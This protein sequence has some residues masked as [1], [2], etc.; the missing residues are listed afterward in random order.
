MKD[1]R[2]LCK[3]STLKKTKESWQLNVLHDPRLDPVMEENNEFIKEILGLLTKRLKSR[4][5]NR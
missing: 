2:W 3:W 1:K 4:C 5:Q